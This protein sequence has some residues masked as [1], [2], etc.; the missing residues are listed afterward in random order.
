MSE[1]S[2]TPEII[3]T[4]KAI[5]VSTT[6]QLHI[7]SNQGASTLIVEEVDGLDKRALGNWDFFW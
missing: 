6:I 2:Y 1:K 7:G 4:C 3:N 5:S